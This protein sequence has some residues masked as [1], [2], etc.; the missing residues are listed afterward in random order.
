MRDFQFWIGMGVYFC[1]FP[2]MSVDEGCG[3]AMIISIVMV[4]KRCSEQNQKHCPHTQTSREQLHPKDSRAHPRN[5]STGTKSRPAFSVLVGIPE[6]EMAGFACHI[7]GDT[8]VRERR[9]IPGIDGLQGGQ[10]GIVQ[11]VGHLDP[12]GTVFRD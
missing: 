10:D 4:K 1:N 6:L 5:K 11:V 2:E 12:A 7:D 9:R 8:R 3:T